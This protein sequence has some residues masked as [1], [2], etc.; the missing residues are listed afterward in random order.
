[1]AFL[2]DRVTQR[3]VR[4]CQ[5]EAALR[6]NMTTRKSIL[7]YARGSI[8]ALRVVETLVKELQ[9]AVFF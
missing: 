6:Q 1:M 7:D 5:Y 2:M 4:S 8:N 3:K 9:S